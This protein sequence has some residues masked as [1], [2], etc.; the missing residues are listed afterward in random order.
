MLA[1]PGQQRPP[2]WVG[3]RSKGAVQGVTSILNHM[4]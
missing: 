4:V 1:E 2:G 3:E